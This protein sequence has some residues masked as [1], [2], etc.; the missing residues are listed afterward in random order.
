MLGA[1]MLRQVGSLAESEQA[2]RWLHLAWQQGDSHAERLLRSLVLPM[3]GSDEEA[4]AAIRDLYRADPWL[5]TRLRLSRRFGLTKLEALAVNPAEGAR[6]WGLVV[7]PNP[8]VT[9]VR[10]AAPRAVPALSVEAQADLRD[11]AALFRGAHPEAGPIEG[12]LRQRSLNQRRRF[13][14]HRLDESMFFA[15]AN[16]MKLDALRR[17][18]KWALRARQPLQSALAG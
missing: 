4:L 9:Q 11:A 17:G 18:R 16:S 7:G 10:L 13:A 15:R 6:P 12:G 8:F 14:Q 1:L 2:I 3:P 5:A